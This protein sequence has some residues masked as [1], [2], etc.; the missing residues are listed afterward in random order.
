[1]KNDELKTI[2]TCSI[3]SNAVVLNNG[4]LKCVGCGAVKNQSNVINMDYDTIDEDKCVKN[5]VRVKING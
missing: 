4:V 1:M 3:C 5:K 2:G